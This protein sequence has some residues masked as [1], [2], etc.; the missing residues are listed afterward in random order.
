LSVVDFTRPLH[1]TV[2]DCDGSRGNEAVELAALAGLRLDPWQE[3]VL[4]ES[5]G[6]NTEGGWAAFEVAMVVPRQ[7]GKGS[8]LE[9]RELAGLFLLDEQFIVHSAHLFDTSLEAFRRLLT[10]IEE[11]PEFDQRV[12]RV[13]RSHGEEGIELKGGQRIRFRSRTRGGGRG[14]SC[15]CLILDESM[16]LPEFAHGALVPTLSA[17]P[18]PQVWYAG[19]AVDELVHADGLVSSRLRERG[20]KG[21]PSLAYFEWAL[22]ATDPELVTP[23]QA[24]DPE[25]WRAANPALEIRISGEHVQHE[26]RA[27]D[28]RTFAVERLGVGAWPDLSGVQPTVISIADWL[29]LED[30]SS[31]LQDPVCVAF[32]VSPDRRASIAAAGRNQ[33]GLWHVEIVENREG[34]AWVTAR[35]AQ[36]EKQHQP[37]A[38]I[39]DGYGPAAS[40]IDQL[41]RRDVQVTTVSAGEHAQGCGKLID[42]VSERALRHLGTRELADAIRGAAT[43]KLGDSWAWSRRNSSVDI[44]PLVASTLA[45][46]GAATLELDLTQPV[47]W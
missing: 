17:M 44:S 37:V 8:V 15:D 18:N 42:V 19:S 13:R 22:D 9:A 3:L 12:R 5:L 31:R 16:F 20:L 41:E 24:V 45:L 33:D 30:Q 10:R 23:E 38:T 29:E 11:T 36:L 43:R 1:M 25:S 46:W 39:C 28:R 32:D 47:I 35:L 27:L 34:T 6:V 7:N 2:P 40:L 21:D 26:Q 14:F 4:R